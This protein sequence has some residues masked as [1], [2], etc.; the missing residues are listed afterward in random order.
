MLH[1]C[2]I[3]FAAFVLLGDASSTIG[4]FF[5]VRN[6]IFPMWPQITTFLHLRPLTAYLLFGW[7]GDGLLDQ[8]KDLKW[9]RW[10]KMEGDRPP[11]P[12]PIPAFLAAQEG[13]TLD[14]AAPRMRSLARRN[15]NSVRDPC[16][17][18]RILRYAADGNSDL[19]FPAP[20]SFFRPIF[21]IR[22]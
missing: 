2:D 5:A 1:F 9:G 15:R 3:E 20:V 13:I 17:F 12:L 16:P 19:Y 22:A 10:G 11:F 8:N 4:S 7:R 21:F 14:L 6:L 18:L